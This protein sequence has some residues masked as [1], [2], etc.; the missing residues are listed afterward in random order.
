MLYELAEEGKA[1]KIMSMIAL[2]II[3]LFPLSFRIA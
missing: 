1:D 3:G 2:K